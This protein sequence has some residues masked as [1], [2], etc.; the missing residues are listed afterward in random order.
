MESLHDCEN[1][2]TNFV[3]FVSF[4]T[5]DQG[6]LL[7]DNGRSVSLLTVIIIAPSV[8]LQPISAIATSQVILRKS[9]FL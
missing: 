3:D 8:N 9:V 5:M 1:K 6:R 7:V 2:I 4:E